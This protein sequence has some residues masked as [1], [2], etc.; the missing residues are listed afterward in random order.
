MDVRTNLVSPYQYYKIL[1]FSRNSD[2]EIYNYR[3]DVTDIILFFNF[4]LM[5]ASYKICNKFQHTD[6]TCST[7]EVIQ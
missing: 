4:L 2:Y 7:I 6:D 3:N 5:S 1:I